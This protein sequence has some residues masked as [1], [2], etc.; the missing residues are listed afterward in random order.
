MCWWRRALEKIRRSSRLFSCTYLLVRSAWSYI[1]YNL[2]MLFEFFEFQFS[3]IFQCIVFLCSNCDKKITS[4]LNRKMSWRFSWSRPG[5]ITNLFPRTNSRAK[6]LRG[7][8]SVNRK[9]T[10]L[11]KMKKRLK[12]LPLNNEI[13]TKWKSKLNSD[14][15]SDIPRHSL[16]K[17]KKDEN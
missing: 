10:T 5:E 6:G 17:T 14:K 15:T 13:G 3:L 11:Q 8:N 16:K 1:K 4:A 9:Q 7:G 12:S 2:V